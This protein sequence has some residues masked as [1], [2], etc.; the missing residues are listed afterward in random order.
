DEKLIYQCG[1]AMEDGYHAARVLLELDNPPTAIVAINDLLGMAAISA[2][3]DLG[4]HVPDDVSI[5]GFDD[6]PFARFVVPKL[7]T[8]ASNPEQNGRK[9][10]QLLH[11]R[12]KGPDRPHEV[13]TG[14]WKL[15]VRGS[16]G[17]VPS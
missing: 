8:V 11:K 3:T 1:P 7:T 9:A 6:I 15:I 2:A 17:S 13:S 4:L 14:G 16:T 12:L 10:V 5:A